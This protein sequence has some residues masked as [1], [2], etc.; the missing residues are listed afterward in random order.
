MYTARTVKIGGFAKLMSIDV[1]LAPV[2]RWAIARIED[3]E[4]LFGGPLNTAAVDI[5]TGIFMPASRNCTGSS[6][7]DIFSPNGNG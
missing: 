2:S 4:M 5:S 1:I 3:G 6:F 7:G